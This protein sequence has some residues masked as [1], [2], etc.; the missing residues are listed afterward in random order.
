MVLG[1]LNLALRS[2]VAPQDEIQLSTQ[3]TTREI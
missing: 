2:L 3:A 1:F